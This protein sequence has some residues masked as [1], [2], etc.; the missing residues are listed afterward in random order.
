V[1]CRTDDAVPDV[2]LA[3]PN[4][5]LA[6]RLAELPTGV[7]IVA[8]MFVVGWLIERSTAPDDPG[9]GIAY[10]AMAAG[11]LVAALYE[12]VLTGLVGQTLGKRL[13]HVKVVARASGEP[14]GIARSLIRFLVLWSVWM[15]TVAALLMI[16]TDKQRRRGLHDLAADTVV[17]E[18]RR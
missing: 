11:M 10:V 15:L 13:L 18:A 6:A 12:V 16:Y 3:S 8:V 9:H 5:R 7:A 14:P 2:H 4:R 1:S 17:I